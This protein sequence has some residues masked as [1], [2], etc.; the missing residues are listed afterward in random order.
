MDSSILLVCTK[1][2]TWQTLQS[3]QLYN[4]KF[5]CTVSYETCFMWEFVVVTTA[6]AARD[7]TTDVY[8]FILYDGRRHNKFVT[9]K[10]DGVGRKRPHA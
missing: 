9:R 8:D 7:V 4:E 10:H 5:L 6:V 1:L 2:A 3:R